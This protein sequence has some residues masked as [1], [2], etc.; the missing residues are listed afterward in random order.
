MDDADTAIVCFGG[1]AR[2]AM[3]ALNTARAAGKKV[4]MFRP[5]TVWP[6]P[7]KQLKARLGGLKRLL[8]VE[9]NHGQMLLEVQR[10]AAGALPVD[11]LGRI[12]GTVISPGDI[13]AKLD[14]MEGNHHAE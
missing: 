12:D 2:A 10:A 8:M 4:G 7:E 14:E 9:H 3:D 11:F 6:F 1:T 13:L 5:I